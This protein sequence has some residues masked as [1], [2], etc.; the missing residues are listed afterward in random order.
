MPVAPKRTINAKLI[1]QDIR[2][3]LGESQIKEK[4]KL[5]DKGY[6][7][8]VQKLSDLGL[9]RE[10]A[11]PSRMPAPKQQPDPTGRELRV[12]WR[13]PSCGA[14]QTR[15]YDECPNCGIIASKVAAIHSPGYRESRSFDYEA[16]ETENGLSRN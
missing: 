3:G 12:A 7:S 5:S 11:P 13:C 16:N 8:V 10:Q 6:A 2:S 4:F 14:P 15:V 1:L 9:L